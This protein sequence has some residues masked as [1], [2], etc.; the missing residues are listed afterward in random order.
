MKNNITNK[1]SRA[2]KSLNF[3]DNYINNGFPKQINCLIMD[4]IHFE[5]SEFL[6][7]NINHL[8]TKKKWVGYFSVDELINKLFD[9]YLTYKY[10]LE[11]IKC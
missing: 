2:I 7:I 4:K 9:K 11:N 1:Y 3:Q 6:S 5:N 8:Q 10:I